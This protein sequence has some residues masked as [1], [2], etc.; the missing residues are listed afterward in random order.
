VKP[1]KPIATV[2]TTRR[3]SSGPH[4]SLALAARGAG[5]P[6]TERRTFQLRLSGTAEVPHAERTASAFATISVSTT[7]QRVCWRFGALRG[8]GGPLDGAVLREGARGLAGPVIEVL[9]EPFSRVGCTRMAAIAIRA[10]VM[11]PA[12]YFVSLL[13]RRYPAGAARAQL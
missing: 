12:D 7:S 1:V 8:L 5:R 6:R 9:G 13:S 11:D 3:P 2:R 10:I 4:R